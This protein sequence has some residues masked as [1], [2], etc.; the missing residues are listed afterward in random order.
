MMTINTTAIQLSLPSAREA[1]L[2][3]VRSW[4]PQATG[5]DLAAHWRGG[6]A[7]GLAAL[8]KVDAVDYARSRNYLNGKVSRLSPYL[9]HGCLSS[10]EVSQFALDAVGA[11]AEKFVSEVAYRD[12]FRQA[13]YRFQA[14]ILQDM[15]PA[16]VLL[17][18]KPLPAD[19]QSGQSGVECMDAVVRQLQQD[20]YVH[21]HARMWFAAYVL[22]WLKVDWRRAADWF[23]AALLDG[24]LASNHLSWQWVASTFS[25]KPYFFN[26]ENVQRFAGDQYCK[27][28]KAQC[29]F[30]DTYEALQQ[31]LFIEVDASTPGYPKA[32]PLQQALALT[33][34]NDLPLWVHDEML[35]SE[36]AML[37]TNQ[38][39]VFIFDPALYGHWPL[40]RLQWMA[41]AL[42]EMPNVQLWLGATAQ[43]WQQLGVQHVQSQRTP[44][45][46][47]H[48]AI[49]PIKVTWCAEP[50]FAEAS[51]SDHH[52][53]RF[54]RY[55]KKVGP[56][57]MGR[58]YLD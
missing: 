40:K 4:F 28:C 12:F 47:L 46:K 37:N 8:R 57:V 1:R 18:Q 52:L 29:P 27:Q 22:H 14:S 25:H 26:R 15:E 24:D 42:A 5:P 58:H 45:A 48:A 16:K 51:L 17:G 6:R 49:A 13:W 32:R 2:A 53:L 23:E 33:P 3:S 19:L 50:P 21:N 34:R 44:Q 56:A 20:G 11:R 31:Q 10:Q 30:D 43:V 39:K 41:D 38:P 35:S 54:T 7:A 55:W 9:R 36:H